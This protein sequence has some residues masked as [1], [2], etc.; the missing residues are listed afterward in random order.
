MNYLNKQWR[1]TIVIIT[2]EVDYIQTICS[3]AIILSDGEIQYNNKTDELIDII[4]RRG[5]YLQI[6]F[7]EVKN[8][9]AFHQLVERCY[10]A[11]LSAKKLSFP[12]HSEEEKE[13]LIKECS[14][15]LSIQEMSVESLKLREVLEDV[16]KE[17]MANC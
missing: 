10:Q 12:I 3:R 6:G 1:T 17:R 2:H 13:L 16:I 5:Q 15:I 4:A 8:S 11:D 7:A 14:A 9:E